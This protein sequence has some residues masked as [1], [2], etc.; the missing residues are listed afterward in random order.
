[1]GAGKR[2]TLLI[3]NRPGSFSQPRLFGHD[4]LRRFQ[5]HCRRQLDI[6]VRG[7]LG[8]QIVTL[9]RRDAGQQFQ[10]LGEFHPL[11][12]GFDVLRRRCDLVEIV[13]AGQQRAVAIDDDA[14]RRLPLMADPGAGRFAKLEQLVHDQ[15][16]N[17]ADGH[18]GEPKNK[19]PEA[20]TIG[21]LD[22]VAGHERIVVERGAVA[23][24]VRG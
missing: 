18:D 14:T 7:E 16:H 8:E 12:I 20:P 19:K 10:L 1:L 15:R 9:G 13:I 6:T 22:R 5:R 3:A 4:A 11:R 17:H 2:F 23:L 24:W 21:L